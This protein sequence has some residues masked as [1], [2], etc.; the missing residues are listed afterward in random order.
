MKNYLFFSVLL[1]LA[2]AS[3]AQVGINTT[4]PKATLDVIGKPTVI[5]EVDGIMAPRITGD[6]LKAKDAI[7]GS[8]QTGVIVYVTALPSPTTAKT[9]NINE[10]GHYYFDGTVWSKLSYKN[11]ND[12]GDIKSSFK[13]ADHNGWVKLDGRAKSSLTATQLSNASALGI[14]TNLPD[15]TGKILVQETTIASTSAATAIAL[16]QLPN[17][18]LTGSTSADGTHTHT[19]DPAA[20]T[21]STNGAHNHTSNATGTAGNF[22]LIRRSTNN[23]N[24][25]A[26]AFDTGGS[27]NE[28][29]LIT[30]VAALTINSNGDHN[31]TTDIPSTTSSTN[32]NHNH[33]ITTSSIN[34]NVTQQTLITD[35][36]PRVSVNQFIYLG[37]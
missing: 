3:S 36:L 12:F 1:F 31:H 25:T 15:A 5:T 2:N 10:V 6:E 16:N 28:P 11:L 19:V 29:D 23:Q 18:S 4:D 21:S 24:A 35:N 8:N 17:V 30:T 32:G 22:G 20:V 7:Y 13:T 26:S 34:G 33:T 9:I 14:G 37:Q 27:G